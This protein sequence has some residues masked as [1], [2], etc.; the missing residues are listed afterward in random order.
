MWAGCGWEG[1]VKLDRCDGGCGAESPDANGRHPAN[2]WVRVRFAQNL[3]FRGQSD[4]YDK[5]FCDVCWP[6]VA[7]A[8]LPVK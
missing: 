5:L 4:H 6:R 8:M 7:T 1:A 2:H 3:A